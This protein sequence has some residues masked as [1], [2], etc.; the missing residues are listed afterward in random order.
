MRL[1]VRALLPSRKEAASFFGLAAPASALLRAALALQVV[2]G[3][4][5]VVPYLGIWLLAREALDGDPE[6]RTVWSAVALVTASAVGGFVTRMGAYT[7]SHRADVR[8]QRSVRH[9]VASHL[10]TL[11]LG[12]FSTN[13]G[14]GALDALQGDTEQLHDAVAH[15]RM[16]LVAATVTPAV[17]FGWLL[18]VDWRLAV[19]V[20]LPSL[21]VYLYQQKVL[22]DAAERVRGAGKAAAAL[23]DATTE[24][25][26]DITTL[27]V[28][29]RDRGAEAGMVAAADEFRTAVQDAYEQDTMK[30]ERS[31]T[32]VDPVA[33]LALVLACG[34]ALVGAGWL[35][36]VDVVPF[37]LLAVSVS[38][39]LQDIVLARSHMRG[40]YQAAD[41]IRQLLDEPPLPEPEVPAAPEGHDVCLTGVTFG[42]RP[43][44]P[45]IHEVDLRL[46]PG[47]VTALVGPSGAGKS[48]LAALV[49]RFH[50]ID[51]GSVRIGGVDV[52]DY[53]SDQLYRKLGF[54]FQDTN[55][56]R[57]TV[58]GNI[59][60]AS[61]GAT[62]EEV[63]AVADAVGLHDRILQ[64]PRGYDSVYGEDAHLSGGECQRVAIARAL[65]ADPE[66]LILDEATA[67][68][69]AEA[70]AVIQGAL[71]RLVA[72][73]TVLVIAH[74]L[75]TVTE[76]DQIVVLDRGRVAQTG[77]HDELASVPGLY[78][79]LWQALDVE[80]EV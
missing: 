11:P 49:A 48:T 73:R 26:R 5:A 80:M 31:S 60:L 16:E 51:A 35:V 59:R 39:P 52:R 38:T 7:L 71:S 41:R 68:L 32:L 77:R 54:V 70:E 46:E 64:L 28:T 44:E 24:L 74:R 78:R 18:T 20:L 47:T 10:T 42:Y 61:P 27:R 76:V 21:L 19:V 12:W 37:A 45:V 17:A 29:R 72:G 40:A 57:T 3:V 14:G 36:P 66:V 65:L 6:A 8:V 34:T 56:L 67:H 13:T 4:L 55:L 2:A 62:G 75:T 23:V 30:I 22:Q 25:V 69:D 33:T 79:D 58:A 15:G 50:D 9:Q 1:A 63:A 53:P 43:D